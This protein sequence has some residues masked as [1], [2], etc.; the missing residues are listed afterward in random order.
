[1]FHARATL[2]RMMLRAAVYELPA[3][4]RGH[5]QSGLWRP[6]GGL[7]GCA[8][9]G[10]CDLVFADEREAVAWLDAWARAHGARPVAELR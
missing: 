7:P 1:M 4:W 9:V 3:G 8:V 5:W 2:P 6:G 10:E